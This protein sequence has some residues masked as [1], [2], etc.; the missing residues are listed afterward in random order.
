MHRDVIIYI[1]E[2]GVGSCYNGKA[3]VELGKVVNMLVQ[4]ENGEY[5]TVQGEFANP[6]GNKPGVENG[7]SEWIVFKD[8]KKAKVFFKSKIKPKEPQKQEAISPEEWLESN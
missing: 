1:E 3:R 8:G 4:L 2:N 7:M 6:K 5:N